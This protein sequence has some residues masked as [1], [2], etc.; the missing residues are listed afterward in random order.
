[1]KRR[2][3]G[4]VMTVIQLNMQRRFKGVR[5]AKRVSTIT[6]ICGAFS[7]SKIL[8]APDVLIPVRVPQPDCAMIS[9]SLFIPTEDQRQIRTSMGQTITY[10]YIESGSLTFSET[11][12]ACEGGEMKI[13][14]KKHENVLKL[15]TVQFTLTEVDVFEKKGRLKTA[16]D[17]YLPRSCNLGFEGCAL[18]AMTLVLEFNKI[19]L[20]SYVRI[21][22]AEFEYL[23][24]DSQ[25][26]L[27]VIDDEHKMI[28]EV[29]DKIEIPSECGIKGWLTKTDFERIFLYVGTLDNGIHMVDASE[30]DLELETRV[31]DSYLVHWASQVNL[32][33][34][35]K[36]QSELCNLASLKMSGDQS[37]LHGTHL[38]KMMGELV[39]EFVCTEVQVRTRA[40]FKAE[41]DACLDHLAVYT[42]EDKLRYMTP[43]TRLLVQ[44][45]V[46]STVN[47]SSH[48]PY[49]F[50]DNDGRMITANPEVREVKVALSDHHFLNAE[51]HNHSKVFKFSSLL[52]TPEEVQAY[53]QM[54]QSHAAEKSAVRKFSS[55]YCGT[56]GECAPSRSTDN[57]KWGRLVN[58]EEIMEQWWT[59]VKERILAWGSIWGICCFLLTMLH[60]IIKLVIVCKNTGKRQL[61]KTAM[62]KFLFVP[63]QELI[64]LFPVTDPKV[65][66]KYVRS[67]ST[68]QLQGA[69]MELRAMANQD[70]D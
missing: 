51:A 32:E 39:S 9:Q 13:Q 64:S 17:G 19:N 50:E 23:N 31:S 30:I 2:S 67:G 62:L 53:E 22:A 3:P 52:Y 60:L 18:E 61:T 26:K 57:F 8:A 59:D 70:Q 48:Y 54:L 24:G 68:A 6:M 12:V 25:D 35:S 66:V 14:G 45:N 56:T 21:R 29:G 65:S 42:A 4:G 47:C 20:C 28:F 27:S 41:G 63:G 40:G 16:E 49:I 55:Y 15:V 5:C 11:N 69:G 43:I 1:M 44:R 33:T 37:I 34:N 10:K 7:H 58:P 36:W 46:V 38:L